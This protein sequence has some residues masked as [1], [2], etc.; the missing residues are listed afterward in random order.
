MLE[1]M[2]NLMSLKNKTMFLKGTKW[3]RHKCA[4]RG[5][6]YY[7]IINGVRVDIHKKESYTSRSNKFYKKCY[8]VIIRKNNGY[9]GQR[10]TFKEATKLA[11]NS[12]KLFL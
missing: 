12:I 5:G 6:H 11:E 4:H 9:M 1:G 3:I 2:T 7:K 8:R 10:T